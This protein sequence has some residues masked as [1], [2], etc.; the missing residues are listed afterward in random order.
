LRNLSKA[1]YTWHIL[2]LTGHTFALHMPAEIATGF[3]KYVLF[4]ATVEPQVRE[5]GMAFVL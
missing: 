3:S 5:T 1:N 2:L 4:S